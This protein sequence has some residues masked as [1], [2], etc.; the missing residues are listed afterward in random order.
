MKKIAHESPLAIMDEIR[1]ATDYCYCLVHLFEKYPEYYKY[2]ETSLKLGREVVL[3]NSIFELGTAFDA[4][5][6]AYWIE[7]LQP[8]YYIIPDVLEDRN[9]TLDQYYNW[10]D[11]YRNLPGK[12]IGVVQGTTYKEIASCYQ[13]LSKHCDKIAIS[14]DYSLYKKLFPH[15][16]E[17]VSWSMGRVV[18]I[19]RLLNDKVIGDKPVHLLGCGTAFEFKFYQ[20]PRYDFIDSIDTSNP[21]VSGLYEITY[22]E[23]G[24]WT[25]ERMKLANLI[26]TKVSLTQL[27]YIEANILAFKKL[28]NL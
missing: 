10:I 17:I 13:H 2:F 5:R 28:V 19:N 21:V 11:K 6:F 16:N 25:K 14:F 26:E 27:Y 18:L 1:N 20:D 8:T 15:E 3:D 24:L 23:S 12:K 9:K 7:K 4:D 22:P